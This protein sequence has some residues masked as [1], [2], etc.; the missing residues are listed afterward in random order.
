MADD[1][2]ADETYETEVAVEK[3]AAALDGLSVQ[4]EKIVE[5]R[6]RRGAGS[7]PRP[8]RATHVLTWRI[9]RAPA[10]EG[11]GGQSKL[12]GAVGFDTLPVQL[13]A[14]TLKRPFEFNIILVGASRRAAGV[15]CAPRRPAHPGRACVCVRHP[16]PSANQARVDWASPPS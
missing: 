4:D 15:R 7:R 6:S 9:G 3:T 5:V 16:P 10:T 14:K 2:D 8:L 13:T 12:T 1:M 11:T